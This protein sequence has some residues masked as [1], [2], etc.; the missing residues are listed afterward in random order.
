MNCRKIWLMR[1]GNFLKRPE[2]RLLW[3]L[4]HPKGLMPS[5]WQGLSFLFPPTWYD[6][7]PPLSHH[8]VQRSNWGSPNLPRR[9]IHLRVHFMLGRAR[10]HFSAFNSFSPDTHEPA[11]STANTR[12]TRSIVIRE[13][14]LICFCHAT[15]QHC[16]CVPDLHLQTVELT[17]VMVGKPLKKNNVSKNTQV[18]WNRLRPSAAV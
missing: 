7:H 18:I 6:S 3:T 15:E 1:L 10:P 2:T 5:T 13:D 9:S 16:L 4:I 17:C 14:V 11:D 12:Q 8:L